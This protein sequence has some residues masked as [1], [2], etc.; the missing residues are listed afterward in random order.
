[1]ESRFVCDS[2]RSSFELFPFFDVVDEQLSVF[3]FPV[4]EVSDWNIVIF[5]P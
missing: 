2:F 3:F 1:M 4:F 5:F